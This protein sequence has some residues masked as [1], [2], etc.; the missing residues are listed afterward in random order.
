MAQIRQLEATVR[1]LKGAADPTRLRLLSLLCRGELTVGEICRV[2][3]QSQ[4]RISRHLRLLTE[5]GYL[6]RFREQ[7]CVYYRTP[8]DG[9]RFGWLRQL[10]EQ[11]GEEPQLQRDRERAV[12][13]VAERAQ[14]A[15]RQ[16]NEEAGSEDPTALAALV[17]DTVGP[18]GIG[19]L[20][21]IGTGSGRMLELLARRAQHAVGVDI[22]TPALRMARARLQGA[23]LSH[24]EF[25]RGDMYQLPCGDGAFDTV[26]MDRVLADAERPQAALLEAARAL[27][28]E[29]RLIV[30][31]DFERIEAHGGGNPLR[32]LRQWLD[33][34][35]FTT[36][37]LRPCDLPGGHY[38]IATAQR[39][40]ARETRQ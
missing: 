6:D 37:R 21:D 4:P 1:A 33:D 7:Q 3:G 24:C 15:A 35:G 14:Q 23:G 19:A 22:S 8:A 9:A 16:L 25:H 10:L 17:L 5:A 18:V 29:G 30:V 26:T 40:A 34:A 28:P 39:T 32:R 38:L 2:L 20:L 11:L 36:E 31:E 12:Q 27:R 13:L